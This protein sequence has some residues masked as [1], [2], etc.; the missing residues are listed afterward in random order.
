MLVQVRLE[1]MSTDNWGRST[2]KPAP[3]ATIAVRVAQ[4]KEQ[5][6]YE[7]PPRASTIRWS[8]GFESHG[9]PAAYLGT[10]GEIAETTSQGSLK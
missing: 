3:I 9:E 8:Q 5:V 6:P 1:P 4:S 7:P 2:Q 10:R